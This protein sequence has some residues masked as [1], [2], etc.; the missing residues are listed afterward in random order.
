VPVRLD[1]T[2]WWQAVST[3]S[4][5]PDAATQLLTTTRT[6]WTVRT[7]SP[8]AVEAGACRASH[9]DGDAGPADDHRHAHAVYHAEGAIRN[10]HRYSDSYGFIDA[11]TDADTRAEADAD[12]DGCAASLGASS[13]AD[14]LVERAR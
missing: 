8:R 9:A 13:P 10:S 12:P 4:G 14:D 2:P 6:F 5:R 1:L 7:G 11:P 3:S